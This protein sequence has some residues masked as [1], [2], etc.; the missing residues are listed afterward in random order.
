MGIVLLIIT[1]F[2]LLVPSSGVLSFVVFI[3]YFYFLY[4]I[5]FRSARI[6]ARKNPL[7]VLSKILLLL[8]PIAIILIL[9]VYFMQQFSFTNYEV[10]NSATTNTDMKNFVPTQNQGISVVPLAT[11]LMLS[12]SVLQLISLTVDILLDKIAMNKYANK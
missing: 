9:N 5:F 7:V 12:S 1:L 3:D 2:A 8:T 6:K 10:L 11:L 4:L